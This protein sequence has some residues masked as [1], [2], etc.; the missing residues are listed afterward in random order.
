MVLKNKGI[1]PDTEY[2]FQ[3]IEISMTCLLVL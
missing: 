1:L 2:P 3:I